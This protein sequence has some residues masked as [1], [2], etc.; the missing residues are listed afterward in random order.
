MKPQCV[1]AVETAIGRALKKGESDFVDAEVRANIRELA[2]SDPN[3]ASMTREQRV[4]AAGQMALVRY[5]QKAAK[6]AQRKTQNLSAQMRESARLVTDAAKLTR[7]TGKGHAALADRLH[8]LQNRIDGTRNHLLSGLMDFINGVEPRFLGLIH[9]RTAM[10]DFAKEVYT[11]GSTGNKVAGKAAKAYTEAT[12]R[13]RVRANAAGADIGKLDYSYLPQPHNLA[14][15]VKA[16]KDAWS[17]KMAGYFDRSRALKDDGSQMN[18]A[19]V[20]DYL[21]NAYDTIAT[22]GRNKLT[23]AAG[24]GRG[25]RASRFDE[26]HRALH[27][28]DADSYVVYMD[29]FGNAGSMYEAIGNHVSGMAK[30]IAMMEEFGPNPNAT[31]T[32]LK[33][34]AEQMDGDSGLRNYGATLDM[35]WNTVNG[36][37]SMPA[38]ARL[39]QVGQA[40][41]NWQVATKL[42]GTMLSSL[43]DAFSVLMSAHHNNVPVGR[44]MSRFFDG[45]GE[46]SKQAAGRVGYAMDFFGSEMSRWHTDNISMGFTSKLAGFVMKVQGLEAWTNGLRRT[47]ALMMG[48]TLNRTRAKDWAALDAGDRRQMELAGVTAEDFA[49]WQ[50]AKAEQVLGVDSLTPDGIANIQGIDESAKNQAIARLLGFIDQE[51]QTAV[52]G[53]DLATRA[54]LQQGTQVGTLGGEFVRMLTLFKTYP[55]AVASRT[56]RRMRAMEDNASRFRYSVSMFTG[57]TAMGAVSLW[58]KDIAAGKDPRDA[59]TGKFLGAAMMQGGGAG[60]LGDIFYTGLGGQSRNGLPNYSNLAGPVFGELGALGN[61]TLG[62]VGELASG[63]KTSLYQE[64]FRFARGNTPLIN[65]W[66]LRSAI[67]HA[68][69]DDMQES[70]S[71][72]Y[73][74]RQTRRSGSEWGNSYWWEMGEG[75]PSR[76]PDL[77]NITGE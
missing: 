42:A 63:D 58:A 22:E 18:D 65:L 1:K 46:E 36:T 31:F 68:V 72:G 76:A 33:Q 70:I 5:S 71:P 73:M 10:V 26:K 7:A 61:L 43:P 53:G 4:V 35:T 59:T 75:L 9:D 77:T 23:P 38:S 39:A 74:A 25:S 54:A 32:L 6:T 28:K 24:G 60:I 29:E 44:A 19:E 62:N 8:A 49:I 12:E 15:I 48:E 66:Y 21:G 34:S 41:R 52:V 3:F 64:A 30:T 57:L 55:F 40:V 56:I 37:T 20:L 27:F 16:G 13:I 2:R 11:P 14:S 51:S 17:R 67:N 69:L 50:Q 47:H 45:F